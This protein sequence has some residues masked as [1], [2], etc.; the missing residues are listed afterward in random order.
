MNYTQTN[1]P[2]ELNYDIHPKY[3]SPSQAFYM[4]NR[5]FFVNI[6]GQ[7]VGG[8]TVSIS[9][10][11]AANYKVCDIEFA[12]G[13]NYSIGTYS[14]QKTNEIYVFIFNSNAVNFIYRV[15]QEQCE[16]VYDGDCIPLSAAPNR[17]ITQWRAYLDVKKTCKNWGGKRLIWTD[18]NFIGCLDVEASIVTNSFT[19]SLFN[20]CGN[21]CDYVSLCVPAPLGCLKFEYL[22]RTTADNLLPNKIIDTGFQFM[23]RWVYYDGRKSTWSDI[24]SYY[25]QSSQE[26]FANDNGFSR[27]MKTRL[28]VGNAM[29]A[30]IE[31]AYRNDNLENWSLI[32]R[33]EKYQQYNSAQEQWYERTL[34]QDIL[35]NG[36]SN[37]DCAFD[38]IFCNDKQC[39]PIDVAD[40]N[41]VFNPFPREAQGLIQ[42]GESI[43]FYNYKKGNCPL[44]KT[45]VDSLKVE[46]NCETV[47]ECIKEYATVKVR[48]IVH[49]FT[50]QYNQFIYIKDENDES[51]KQFG[52]LKSGFQYGT[53]V[54]QA[55]PKDVKGFRVYI[56]GADEYNSVMKQYRV[57][58]HSA[59]LPITSWDIE[60]VDAVEEMG[61]IFVQGRERLFVGS[62]G[63][64]MQETELKVPKGMRGF[65]RME[66]HLNKNH[67]PNTSTNVVGTTDIL[68]YYG[69][70]NI[71]SVIGSSKE[72]YFDTCNGDV[73]IVS[74]AFVIGDNANGSGTRNISGYL[75]DKSTNPVEGAA[76]KTNNFNKT[77]TDWNGY[78]NIDTSVLIGGNPV[79]L[80]VYAELDC[81]D[82]DVVK[83]ESVSAAGGAMTVRDI[84]IENETYTNNNYEEIIVKVVD[85]DNEVVSGLKVALSGS[86]YRITNNLGEAIFRIRQY[87]SRAR[88]LKAVLMSSAGCFIKD[89]FGECN[90]CM[91][92]LNSVADECFITTPTKDIGTLKINANSLSKSQGFLKSGGRYNF[93]FITKGT[94]GK[95]SFVNKG[96]YI[97][98]PKKCDNNTVCSLKYDATN[99]IFPSD[100][101]SVSIVR[102]ENLND[103]FLLQWIVDEVE[104]VGGNIKLTIQSLN[105]YNYKYSFKTNTIYE[106]LK[107]DR[108]EFIADENG[109]F[110]CED[111]SYQILSPFKDEL[112]SGEEDTTNANYFNQLLIQDDSR[113][114]NIKK[115]TV[116]EL[117]RPKECATEDIFYTICADLEVVDARVL[118]PTGEFNTFDTYLV[119]RKIGDSPSFTFEHHSP[120]DFWGNRISDIGTAHV[121][122]EFEDE[123]RFGRNITVSDVD[124]FGSFGLIEKT[125]GDVGMG[126]I[127]AMNIVDD[128]IILAIFEHDNAVLEKSDDLLRITPS[129]VVAAS[130]DQVI[131]NPAPK[132]SGKYG[133]QYD[134]IGSVYFGDGYASYA[135]V[136]SHAY[137]IHDYNSAKEASL[138]KI[139]SWT[140]KRFQ[141]IETWNKQ[142]LNDLD[143][144][145]FCTGFNM[146]NDTVMLTLKRLRDS[147]IDNQFQS[148]ISPNETITYRAMDGLFRS[149]MSFTPEAYGSINIFNGKGAAFVT[150]QNGEAFLHPV[151]ADKWNEFFGVSVD[152]VVGISVNQFP[153]KSK[154]LLST[155]V[156]DKFMW[157]I[158]KVITDSPNFDSEIPPI[159]F[160][161]TE[162]KWNASY[163]FN[164]NSAGGLFGENGT[165]EAARGYYFLITYIRDNTLNLIYNSVNTNKRTEFDELDIIFNKFLVS[166]QSGFTNN[167]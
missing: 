5:E 4:K 166:E 35:N 104:Y 6:Q 112:I 42:F 89:C 90:F 77:V 84:I 98:I 34:S 69:D 36:Y 106:Y 158:K 38:Y 57:Q 113:L 47:T 137:I 18:G 164:K 86:K 85:C 64:Y 58:S 99:A 135:D 129:G 165:M 144:Y 148:Y 123:K 13:E 146:L 127:T 60:Q 109:K 14:S 133:C 111:L 39:T 94:C 130:A 74:Q 81:D 151:I 44:P 21:P 24:S 167:L 3:L 119:S 11:V 161:L 93:G 147:G 1:K 45:T 29:V 149:Q 16:I 78:Y 63:F 9:T 143:K 54:K 116:I 28:P 124:D 91:P 101:L 56:E 126:D 87:E 68:S 121:V 79:E 120:S 73:D 8:A 66:S 55:F 117:T 23:F 140:A 107:G 30:Y 72:I 88:Q 136:A 12:A 145:R 82:F 83:T 160:E 139:G 103:R 108:I 153:E 41:R 131:S 75:R 17:Q 62:G 118:Y 65:L 61:E 76:I 43:A 31:I 115:G 128:K 97:S 70:K 154:V 142:Q 163:L 10:P 22:P 27:C 40:T 7:M 32:E 95:L 159:R 155:E 49:N 80:K 100:V 125:V 25:F 37:D 150:I 52:G 102:T 156:Q 92:F 157:Y 71:N 19:S 26:C 51:I 134:S 2:T 50:S 152:S 48:A 141:E 132:L 162:S 46:L 114:P 96:N 122:N 67:N 138:N 20:N 110:Y 105:D 15:T 53:E 59:G 33:I